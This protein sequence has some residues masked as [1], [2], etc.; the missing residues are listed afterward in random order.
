MLAL[1]VVNPAVIDVSLDDIG[2]LEHIKSTLVRC[3]AAW[4]LHDQSVTFRGLR[5]FV[6]LPA[7]T[8]LVPAQYNAVI[9]P[10]QQPQLFAT[11]LLRQA[12]GVHDQHDRQTCC[13]T[14]ARICISQLEGC[15]AG[16]LLYGPPGTGKTM[17]AKVGTAP[18]TLQRSALQCKLAAA[19]PLALQHAAPG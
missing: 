13:A 16:V 17:L 7:M 11:S 9:A 12:K 15:A 2:G 5:L 8:M 18:G 4:S 14:C 1:D 6:M 19:L 3:A 10:L